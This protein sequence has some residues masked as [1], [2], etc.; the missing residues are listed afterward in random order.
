MTLHKK[1]LPVLGAFVLVI[2]MGQGCAANNNSN[3]GN[4]PPTTGNN[5]GSNGNIGNNQGSTDGDD[6]ADQYTGD[7]CPTGTQRYTSSRVNMTFCYPAMVNNQAVAIDDSSS[8]VTLRVGNEVARVMSVA[9]VGQ[10]ANR[11][12]T[13]IAYAADPTD[14]T[15]ACTA[16]SVEDNKGREAFILV[17]AKD[18]AQTQDALTACIN[19]SR[20]NTALNN[21]PISKFF[22]Y[23]NEE[24]LILVS[25]SQDAPL[26][27]MTDDFE[28]T[29]WPRN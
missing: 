13:V 19:S 27:D 8:R 10:N 5:T 15:I 12:N 17:G 22:F 11:N 6:N 23:D 4:N 24:E 2:A 20:L 18:N 26:G 16:R 1:I 29:I 14:S 28:A 25:G 3:T 7:P 21:E 9:N